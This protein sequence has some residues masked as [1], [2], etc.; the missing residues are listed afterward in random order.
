MTSLRNPT[1]DQLVDNSLDIADP[2]MQ[3]EVKISH[4]GDVLWVNV[5]PICCLRIC[6]IKKLVV[7]RGKARK[8]VKKK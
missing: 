4:D 6:R 8:T 2:P 1:I 3:V 5:G 7:E